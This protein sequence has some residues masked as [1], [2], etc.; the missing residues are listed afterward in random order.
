M[1]VK[2]PPHP[3]YPDPRLGGQSGTFCHFCGLPL[4]E[5]LRLRGYNGRTG[6]PEYEKRKDCPRVLPGWQS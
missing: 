3:I 4:V 2:Q 6:Q 5:Q 1:T